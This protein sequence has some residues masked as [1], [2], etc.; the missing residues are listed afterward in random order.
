MVHSPQK[1]LTK[2]SLRHLYDLMS[3]RLYPTLYCSSFIDSNISFIFIIHFDLFFCIC[4]EAW[5]EFLFSFS[6]SCSFPHYGLERWSIFSLWNCLCN[7]VKN[8]L[9][10][11][12]RVC[13]W[14]AWFHWSLCL[15]FHQYH[16]LSWLLDYSKSWN[17]AVS[18]PILSFSVFCVL[19]LS[20]HFSLKIFYFLKIKAQ[21]IDV[22][23]FWFPFLSFVLSFF[24]FFLQGH[25]LLSSME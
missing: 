5:V 10:I 1:L 12:I 21:I 22:R 17:L 18:P 24:F 3:Q 15:S 13:I 9:V 6:N 23:N 14:T 25:T 4:Y 2:Q 11:Y 19:A 8:Q 16:P 7:S 20:F